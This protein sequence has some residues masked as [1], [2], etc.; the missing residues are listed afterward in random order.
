MKNSNIILVLLLPFILAAHGN[1][2]HDNDVNIV[3]QEKDI[4]IEPVSVYK[5]INQ[6]YIQSIKPIF[7]K[8]CFDCHGTISSYPWYYKLPGVK[9]MMDYDTKEAK[10]HLDMKNDFPF[11]SHET[12]MQDLKSLKEIG[13]KGNMPPLRYLLGHWDSSLNEEEKAKLIKWSEES[14]KKLE[15]KDYE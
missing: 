7:E 10:E 12:P 15:G 13:L 2:K 6:K 11:V 14:I 5:E 3:K 4:S 9:Q 8:K 1:K